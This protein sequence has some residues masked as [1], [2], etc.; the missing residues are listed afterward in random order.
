[1]SILHL[2]K[3]HCHQESSHSVCN[4]SQLANNHQLPYIHYVHQSTKLLELIFSDVWPP[5]FT[6]IS[7]YKYYISFI[8]DFSKF[9]WIYIMMIIPRSINFFMNL[10]SMLN[11]LLDSKIKCV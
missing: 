9:T 10:K 5:A 11:C 8:D 1:M 7:V 3:L 2:N 6:S 4:S